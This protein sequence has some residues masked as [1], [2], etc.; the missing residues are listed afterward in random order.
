MKPPYTIAVLCGLFLPCSVLAQEDGVGEVLVP[1]ASPP[2]SSSLVQGL[3]GAA[4]ANAKGAAQAVDAAIDNVASL[5]PR[6]A[7]VRELQ[8]RQLDYAKKLAAGEV[9][10]FPEWEA[11]LP[12]IREQ[13]TTLQGSYENYLGMEDGPV[14]EGA[15]IA[16]RQTLQSLGG[17][18]QSARTIPHDLTMDKGQT[19]RLKELRDTEREPSDAEEGSRIEVVGETQV[20]TLIHLPVPLTVRAAPETVV[21]FESGGG[22]VFANGIP[23]TSAT[24][25]ANGTATVYYTSRGGATGDVPIIISSPE[26]INEEEMSVVVVQPLPLIPTAISALQAHPPSPDKKNLPTPPEDLPIPE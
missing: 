23:M 20:Y 2:D 15:A 8:A 16:L 5:P 22:G 9:R 26:A 18:L 19:K 6:L 11:K 1:V 12:E 24:A 17:Y 25:D 13:A 4:A 21:Y 3:K 14:R 10:P 7:R